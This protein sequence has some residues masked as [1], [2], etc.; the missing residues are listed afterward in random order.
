MFR[1][2]LILNLVLFPLVIIFS[3][4]QNNQINDMEAHHKAAVVKIFE[5]F[6]SGNVDELDAIIAENLVDHQLDTSITKKTGLAGTKE[7]FNYFHRVF[8]DM[9]TTIHSMAVSGDTVFIHTTSVGTTSEPFMGM[10]A[11]KKHSIS[12]VDIIRFEGEKA[13]EHW[14][15][16]DV[17]EMMKMMQSPMES[18]NSKMKNK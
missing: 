17:A 18:D 2:F 14:G 5:V 6:D 9:K 16:I 1:Q 10:P 4:C 12:G 7:L 3:S 11:N 8:P 13:V 15:F